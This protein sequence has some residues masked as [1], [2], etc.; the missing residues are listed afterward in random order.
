MDTRYSELLEKYIHHELD[1][2]RSAQVEADIDRHEAISNYLFDQEMGED[3]GFSEG[4]PEPSLKVDEQTKACAKLINQAI[5]RAF[6]KVGIGTACIILAVGLGLSPLMNLLYYNPAEKV[7]KD[8]NRLS[9]DWGIWSELN[10]PANIRQ[11]AIVVPQGYGRYAFTLEQNLSYSGYFTHYSGSITRNSLQLYTPDALNGSSSNLFANQQLDSSRPVSQQVNSDFYIWASGTQEKGAER[12]KELDENRSYYA[13]VT[14][15]QALSLA[16]VQEIVK[17]NALSSDVWY[18]I[19]TTGGEY[20][21]SMVGM[22]GSPNGVQNFYDGGEEYPW[23]TLLQSGTEDSFENIWNRYQDEEIMTAHFLSMLRYI[24]DQQRFRE[25][26]GDYGG[27]YSEAIS[28]VE[29]NGLQIFGFVMVGQKEQLI[30][31]NQ[32]E[33]VFGIY[34]EEIR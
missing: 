23:L 12:L 16:E 8:T 20:Y 2:D 1:A 34:A 30:E 22:W 7:G 15:D 26:V 32:D 19:R 13:Y 4:N 17:R 10:K 18:A 33:Q 21:G 24:N 9:L 31:L 11:N 3:I 6:L 25:M 27:V 29:Q 28:Y 14:L 5:R